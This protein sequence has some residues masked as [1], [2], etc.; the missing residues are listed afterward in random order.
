MSRSAETPTTD[1]HDTRADTD[2]RSNVGSA[3]TGMVLGILGAI[4]G[5]LALGGI[6]PLMLGIV[7]LVLA[8]AGLV[9]GV[10]SYTIAKRVP[11]GSTGAALGGIVLSALALVLSAIPVIDVSAQ[12]QDLGDAVERLEREGTDVAE[13][14]VAD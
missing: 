4:A 3:G 13:G 2:G 12:F 7:G 1:R 8:V 14:D 5:A 9:A 6:L 11:R 10:T